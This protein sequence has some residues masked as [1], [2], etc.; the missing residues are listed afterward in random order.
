MWNPQGE[1]AMNISRQCA[2]T[3][4]LCYAQAHLRGVLAE[5]AGPLLL[6]VQN[7]LLENPRLCG[8]MVHTAKD[9]ADSFNPLDGWDWTLVFVE[10]LR[11]ISRG[12]CLD[13]F[14]R[15]YPQPEGFVTWLEDFEGLVISRHDGFTD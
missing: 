9:A 4:I 3:S 1:L 5:T 10:N 12:S 6:R 7:D 2:A 13:Y 8:V 14:R 11:A 15:N